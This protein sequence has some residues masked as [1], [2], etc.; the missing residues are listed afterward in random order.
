VTNAAP[1][2]QRD[3]PA[4]FEPTRALLREQLA[5]GPRPGSQIEAAAAVAERSLLA[6]TD[7]LDIRC[8]RRQWW[9]PG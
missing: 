6:A 8:R 5:N 3:V 4:D 2:E 9:I 7:V 1:R